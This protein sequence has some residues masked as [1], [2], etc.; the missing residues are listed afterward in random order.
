MVQPENAPPLAAAAPMQPRISNSDRLS[1][2]QDVILV[3]PTPPAHG[4]SDPGPAPE[5]QDIVLIDDDVHL[6]PQAAGGSG[7]ATA[8][9]LSYDLV[10]DF[11]LF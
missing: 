5:S 8:V 10:N 6:P 11:P 3:E 9:R 7:D 1:D 4:G 2:S